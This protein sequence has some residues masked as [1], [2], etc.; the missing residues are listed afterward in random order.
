MLHHTGLSRL[1]GCFKGF[2]PLVKTALSYEALLATAPVIT[3]SK[4]RLL[5]PSAA[6]LLSGWG[7]FV[8]SAERE[9]KLLGIIFAPNKH[10]CLVNKLLR[11]LPNSEIYYQAAEQTVHHSALPPEFKL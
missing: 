9:I 8:L 1:Q 7:L 5:M 3:A 6:A 10:V 11:I 2:H 4:R